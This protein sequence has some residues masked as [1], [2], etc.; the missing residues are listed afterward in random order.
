METSCW[1]GSRDGGGTRKPSGKEMKMQEKLGKRP[2]TSGWGLAGTAAHACIWNFPRLGKMPA[3]SKQ[4]RLRY[5][6]SVHTF[7]SQTPGF[8]SGTY[9]PGHTL[10]YSLGDLMMRVSVRG[11]PAPLLGWSWDPAPPVGV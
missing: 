10:P 2:R 1:G 11:A 6:A 4:H 5:L 3:Q 9:I 8:P 7:C